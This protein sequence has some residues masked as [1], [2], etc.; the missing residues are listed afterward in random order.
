[1]LKLIN[2]GLGRTGTTSLK[3]ALEKLGYGPCYHM[4]DVVNDEKRLGQWERI[5]CDGQRPDWDAV[6][7]GYTSAVDG[8]C[9]IYYKQLMEAYPEAKVMLTVRDAD[10]W[11]RSTYDTLYQFALHGGGDPSDTDSMSSR[12]H[13]LT[14]AM[15]WNGLFGGRFADKDYAIEVFRN[16]NQEVVSTVGLDN[17]LVFDVAEGW[18]PLCAFLGVDV[19]PEDFPHVNDTASMRERLQQHQ[20]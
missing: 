8:P 4:F 1:M 12:V 14:S 17:L 6:F 3:V 20:S 13:R 2:A 18:E 5:V 16:H 9:A 7:E 10:L 11:Y 19:P 15:T